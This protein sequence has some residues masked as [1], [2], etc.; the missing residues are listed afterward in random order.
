MN[1]HP[2]PEAEK[3]LDLGSKDYNKN[4]DKGLAFVI[5]EAKANQPEDA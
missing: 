5:E 1:Q 3:A 4:K 2:D